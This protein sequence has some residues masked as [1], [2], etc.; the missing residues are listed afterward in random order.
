MV[1]VRLRPL[2]A[3]VRERLFENR[4]YSVRGVNALK[5]TIRRRQ[6]SFISKLCNSTGGAGQTTTGSAPGLP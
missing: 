5:K 6:K 4:H 1:L 2:L 3:D